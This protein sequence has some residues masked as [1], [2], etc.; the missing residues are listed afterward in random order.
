[1]TVPRRADGADH[2]PLP[3]H[4]AFLHE[5]AVQVRIERYIVDLVVDDDEAPVTLIVPSRTQDDT[6]V[7]RGDRRAGGRG[8]IDGAVVVA[9]ALAEPAVDRPCK[10]T[11]AV[12]PVG[13]HGTT[14]NAALSASGVTI[15]KDHEG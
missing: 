9:I 2:L 11:A 7:S 13:R 3:Y 14:G 4:V 12:G 15:G 10:V 5:N 8:D 6:A 1:C